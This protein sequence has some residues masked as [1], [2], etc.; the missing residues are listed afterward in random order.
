MPRYFTVA[1]AEGQLPEVELALR[2]ALFQ[3]SE[4]RAADRELDEGL[5]RIRNAGGLRVNPG[6]FLAIRARRDLATAK[7]RDALDKVEE[8]GAQ[9]KDLDIGLID[10][11]ARYHG[12]D[13]CLCWKL[14]EQGI[15][16][17][18]SLEEGFRGRKPID[19]EF[20]ANHKGDAPH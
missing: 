7:L 9:V 3:K 15:H 16:F 10:F 8:L 20:L 18:H 12:R 5:Q 6:P 2:D 4:Y 19:A 14:G 13:V 11:L 1:E 17:W